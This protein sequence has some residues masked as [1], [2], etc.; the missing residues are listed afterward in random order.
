MENRVN[1]KQ[2]MVVLNVRGWHEQH[3]NP[4]DQSVCQLPDGLTYPSTYTSLNTHLE[5]PVLPAM[6]QGL[7]SYDPE[8]DSYMPNS[9][10]GD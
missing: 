4:S 3:V 10:R 5:L 8:D 2:L 1:F 9:I 7:A 6:G